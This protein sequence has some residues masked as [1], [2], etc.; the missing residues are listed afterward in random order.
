[1]WAAMGFGLS[2][3]MRGKPLGVQAPRDSGGSGIANSAR[4]VESPRRKGKLICS[5]CNLLW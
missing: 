1:M 4:C 3:N 2:V 5:A